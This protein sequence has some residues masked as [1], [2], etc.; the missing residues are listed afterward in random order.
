[1]KIPK[2]SV[3]PGLR[4]TPDQSNLKIDTEGVSLPVVDPLG[5]FYQLRHREIVGG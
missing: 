2:V 1:M 3:Y 4:V 5:V